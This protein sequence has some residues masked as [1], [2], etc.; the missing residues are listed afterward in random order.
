M[1]EDFYTTE[2]GYEPEI[3][4][5]TPEVVLVNGNPNLINK[6]EAIRQWITKFAMTGVDTYEIYEGT[7]YGNRMKSLYGRKK[8]GYGYEEAE[9]ERDY[10]EG[11]L[12]CP[13][14]SQVSY[15]NL[16]KNGKIMNINIQVEL[17]DGETLDVSIEKT[18]TL[19]GNI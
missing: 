14:I 15:F 6:Y 3:D 17:Y 8:I 10:K 16:T 9:L 1:S 19:K 18:Y 7:G 13:A 11:L 12:L 4:F 2:I 5:N